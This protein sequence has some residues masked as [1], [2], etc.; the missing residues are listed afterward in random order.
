MGGR[1]WMLKEE[2]TGKSTE[3][4]EIDGKNEDEDRWIRAGKRRKNTYSPRR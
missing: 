4:L 1:F 3:Q 2:K